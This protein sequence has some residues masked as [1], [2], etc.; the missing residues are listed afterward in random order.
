MAEKNGKWKVVLACVGTPVAL[1][2][3]AATGFFHLNT[4]IANEKEIRVTSEKS[5][6]STLSKIVEDNNK[7]H[8]D[9]L[10]QIN[11]NQLDIVQR[12]SK[13]EAHIEK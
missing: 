9:I 10:K 8:A 6:I 5:L 7:T 12:L 3:I 13:I 2:S 11:S 4:A 1:F